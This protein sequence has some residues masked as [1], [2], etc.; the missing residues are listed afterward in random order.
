LVQKKLFLEIKGEG[1]F[2]VTAKKWLY[3]FVR[4][5]KVWKNWKFWKMVALV[6]IR[7]MEKFPRQ[8]WCGRFPVACGGLD[9]AWGLRKISMYL[10]QLPPGGLRLFAEEKLTAWIKSMSPRFFPREFSHPPD[11]VKG[12]FS[13]N[14]NFFTGSDGW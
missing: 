1:P 13:T 6:H 9:F 12:N 11:N 10:K 2:L 4:D 8:K 14:L 7:R 5:E 3:A